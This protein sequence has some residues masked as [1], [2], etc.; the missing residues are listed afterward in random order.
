VSFAGIRAKIEADLT[1]A[2]STNAV[3]ANPTFRVGE[4]TLAMNDKPPRVVWV[5]RPG[6]FVATKQQFSGEGTSGGRRNPRVLRTYRRF[7]DVHCWAPEDAAHGDGHAEDLASALVAA[8]FRQAHGSFEVLADDWTNPPWAANGFVVT[9]TLY[10]DFAVLDRAK[11]TAQATQATFDES[12]APPA[13][14]LQ[15]P[16][17]T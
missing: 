16:G 14:T 3:L 13:G 6:Q 1:A 12:S 2:L 8:C 10:F 4:R 5:P 11:P 15:A 9:V 17:D 7:F